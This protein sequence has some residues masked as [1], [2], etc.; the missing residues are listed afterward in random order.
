[1]TYSSKELM[2]IGMDHLVRKLGQV[3]AERFISA[4]I[5]ESS[6]Y[7]KS[8][9]LLFDD[10]SVDQVLEEA[11]STSLSISLKFRTPDWHGAYTVRGDRQGIRVAACPRSRYTRD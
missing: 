9:R 4:V 3:D 8:R 5:R 7:T 10:M 11:P 2:S 6:D 1:M